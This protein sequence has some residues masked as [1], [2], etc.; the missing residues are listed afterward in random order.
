MFSQMRGYEHLLKAIEKCTNL[1]LLIDLNSLVSRPLQMLDS[2]WAMGC[3]LRIFAALKTSKYFFGHGSIRELEACLQS[4]KNG[5]FNK[6]RDFD[7]EI[8]KFSIKAI[9]FQMSLKLYNQNSTA[10]SRQ[11]LKFCSALDPG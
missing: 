8:K 11:L 7:I 1:D 6:S 10:S 9:C 2:N 3:I 4:L 5:I